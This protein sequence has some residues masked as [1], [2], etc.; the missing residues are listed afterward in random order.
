MQAWK[1]LD[2]VIAKGVGDRVSLSF[3]SWG[4]VPVWVC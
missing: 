3:F 1:E 4:G 2:E